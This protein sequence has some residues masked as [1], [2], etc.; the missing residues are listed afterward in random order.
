MDE[1]ITYTPVALK[2]VN[3]NGEQTTLEFNEEGLLKFEQNEKY[4]S[5]YFLK[6]QSNYAPR[7]LDRLNKVFR[8]SVF[9]IRQVLG[10][11]GKTYL[12]QIVNGEII[13]RDEYTE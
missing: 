2:A 4:T 11:D 8:D 7:C 12:E 10:S 3:A 6:E 13:S 9:I 1:Q 5:Y